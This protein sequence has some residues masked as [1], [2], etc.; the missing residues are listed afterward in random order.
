MSAPGD[1]PSPISVAEARVLPR[2]A[3]KSGDT[4]QFGFS[5]AP[6]LLWL[7]HLKDVIDS[8][9]VSSPEFAYAAQSGRQIERSQPPSRARVTGQGG[10]LP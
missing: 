3:G 7:K 5:E 10:R 1:E 2:A 9:L 4:I 8:M 6:S